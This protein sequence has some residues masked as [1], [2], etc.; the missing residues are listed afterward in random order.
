MRSLA[1]LVIALIA[2]IL[3]FSGIARASDGFAKVV[4]GVAL[5]LFIFSLLFSSARHNIRGQ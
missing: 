3:G 2:G 1:F 4:F 5:V